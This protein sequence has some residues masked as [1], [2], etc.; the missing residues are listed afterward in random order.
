MDI[1]SS[2]LFLGGPVIAA[3]GFVACLV[4]RIRPQRLPRTLA[5]VGLATSLPAALGIVMNSGYPVLI[6][7]PGTVFLGLLT[8]ASYFVISAAL[9]LPFRE[10]AAAAAILIASVWDGVSLAIIMVPGFGGAYCQGLPGTAG[11]DRTVAAMVK[12]QDAWGTD[13]GRCGSNPAFTCFRGPESAANGRP[14]S[15][16]GW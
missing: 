14:P 13:A 3:F 16:W 7:R 2:L 12:L 8:A 5:A 15:A 4:P 10:C 6:L 9:R 11:A 1:F